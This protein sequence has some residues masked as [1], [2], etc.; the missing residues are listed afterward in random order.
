I[1]LTLSETYLP[2]DS[3]KVKEGFAEVPEL[4]GMSMR[5]ATNILSELGLK[6]A[7]YRS[8][9][10]E[11]QFPKAG[12]MMKLGSAVTIRGK[13]KPLELVTKKESD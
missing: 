6:A 3:S 8:G 11:R 12:D 7:S 5:Q 10:I 1:I 2:V 4:R 9:T 13:A